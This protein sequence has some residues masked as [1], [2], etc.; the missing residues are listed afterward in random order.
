MACNTSP[1]PRSTI[2]RGN[3]T[4]GN[5]ALNKTATQSSTVLGGDASRAI[6]GNTDGDWWHNSVTHTGNPQGWW[7]VDLGSSQAVGEVRV[8]NRTDCCANRLNDWRVLTSNDP[9]PDTLEQALSTPGVT[10]VHVTEQ[11]GTPTGVALPAGTTGRYV[12]IWLN[13]T[14]N[15]LSLAEVEVFGPNPPPTS[16]PPP[17]P[18]SPPPA[19]PPPASP[20]PPSPPGTQQSLSKAEVGFFTRGEY[21]S[22]AGW[23]NFKNGGDPQAPGFGLYP[24]VPSNYSWAYGAAPVTAVPDGAL[25]RHAGVGYNQLYE[26]K[27]DRNPSKNTRVK[28]GVMDAQ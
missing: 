16:P 24:T 11:A 1:G 9:F 6:D 10:D 21:Q 13:D 7:Q 12:R 19:S 3:D 14:N 27:P 2:P 22:I 8:W 4:P 28:Y 5:V 17:S 23:E 26:K 25:N 20:P 15:P 18:P